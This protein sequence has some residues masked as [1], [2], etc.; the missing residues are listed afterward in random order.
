M[1]CPYCLTDTKFEMVKKGTAT[2]VISD[3]AE[4]KKPASA[5]PPPAEK[6]TSANAYYRCPNPKCRMTIPGHYV[7]GYEDFP[8][9]IVSGVG[10]STHG[11]SVY[12]ASL[13]HCLGHSELARVWRPFL[14]LALDDDSLADL[15]WTTIAWRTSTGRPTPS[16]EARCP[17]PRR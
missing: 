13:F 17:K 1:I 16:N 7:K 8:P 12:L 2:A 10:F 4:E 6:L 11:K 9:F 5:P 14:P 3:D 15:N